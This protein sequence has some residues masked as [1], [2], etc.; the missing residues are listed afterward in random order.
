MEWCINMH[1]TTHNKCNSLSIDVL[2]YEEKFVA[3][4]CFFILEDAMLCNRG[5]TNIVNIVLLFVST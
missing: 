5:E 1:I 3:A 2:T 4:V